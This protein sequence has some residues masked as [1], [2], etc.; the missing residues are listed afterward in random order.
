[1]VMRHCSVVR[2]PSF[3][4]EQCRRFKAKMEAHQLDIVPEW[5]IMNRF[6]SSTVHWGTKKEVECLLHQPPGELVCGI[7]LISHPAFAVFL[8][9]E[10]ANTRW[11]I[12]DGCHAFAESKFGDVYPRL[13]IVYGTSMLSN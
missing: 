2:F 6:F 8:H 4:T 12:V 7:Y 1:M 5:Q 9:C 3:F 11:L 10:T 13:E